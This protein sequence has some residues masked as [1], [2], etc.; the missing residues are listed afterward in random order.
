MVTRSS[1]F[2]YEHKKR[3]LWRVVS[4]F[5][6]VQLLAGFTLVCRQVQ[7]KNKPIFILFVLGKIDSYKV[8]F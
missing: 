3:H 7:E 6:Y 2:K 5:E 1:N 4:P 8:S